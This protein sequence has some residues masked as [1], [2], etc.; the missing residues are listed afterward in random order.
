MTEKWRPKK[1]A[2]EDR[3]SKI[4]LPVLFGPRGAVVEVHP[5]TKRKSALPEPRQS[6]GI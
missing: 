6:G 1:R 4:A 5:Q 3:R 2:G